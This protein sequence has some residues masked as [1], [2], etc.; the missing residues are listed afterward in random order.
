MLVAQ[1]FFGGKG[2][3][4]TGSGPRRWLEIGFRGLDWIP[5]LVINALD[6]PRKTLFRKWNP[7]LRDCA[8]LLFYAAQDGRSLAGRGEIVYLLATW[9][10]A[11]SL[12][13]FVDVFS[14][15]AS[16]TRHPAS[17]TC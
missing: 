14:R 3:V 12:I 10:N 8:T 16:T 17:L 9:T 4:V 11:V 13:G 6:L 2:R 1:R 7:P 15:S 5:F